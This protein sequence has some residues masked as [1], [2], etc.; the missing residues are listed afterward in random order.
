MFI[1]G[2]FITLAWLFCFFYYGEF[3]PRN[4]FVGMMIAGLSCMGWG[5]MVGKR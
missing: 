1:L 2:A 3:L 5:L 4:I